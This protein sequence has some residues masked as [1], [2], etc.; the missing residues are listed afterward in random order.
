MRVCD[1]HKARIPLP[2]HS[3]AISYPHSE[4]EIGSPTIFKHHDSLRLDHRLELDHF[5]RLRVPFLEMGMF[6]VTLVAPEPMLTMK[7]D[8]GTREFANRC[9][10]DR[11]T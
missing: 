10:V 1:V 8:T 9:L 7:T 5:T 3:F 2:S 4:C 6:T 11:C